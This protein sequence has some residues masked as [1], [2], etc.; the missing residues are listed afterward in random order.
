MIYFH[1][2]ELSIVR[3]IKNVPQTKKDFFSQNLRCWFMRTQAKFNLL[4]Y[5]DL[6]KNY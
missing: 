6:G 5:T 4:N 3:Y 1:N 2:N